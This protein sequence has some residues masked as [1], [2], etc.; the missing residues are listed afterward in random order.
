MKRCLFLIFLSVLGYAQ[1]NW[2]Y[3]QIDSVDIYQS[4]FGIINCLAIDTNGNP[5]VVYC[6]TGYRRGFYAYRLNDEW[7]KDRLVAG[8]VGHSLAY[9]FN[10]IAHLSFYIGDTTTTPITLLCYGTR[11]DSAN[12][13]ISVIDTIHY[14]FPGWNEMKTSLAFDTAG[15]PAIAYVSHDTIQPQ[16]IKYAHYNGYFWDTSVVEYE[17][18]NNRWT[19]PPSLKFD[20]HNKPHIVFTKTEGSGVVLRYYTYDSLNHW[21][22]RWSKPLYGGGTVALDLELDS[23]QYP[24]IA[25]GEGA[26]L[27]YSW[28]DGSSWQ[29]DYIT[30][31]GW[32]GVRIRLALDNYD[33]PHIIYLPDM[34][35][36]V[37]YCYK[38]STWHNVWLCPDTN[39]GTCTNQDIDIQF[40]KKFCIMHA[41]YPSQTMGIPFSFLSHAWGEVVTKINEGKR[42]E[43][44]EAS[45]GFNIYPNISSGLLNV[46]WIQG[47][48]GGIELTIYDVCGKRVKSI[49][50]R[51][52]PIGNCKKTLNISDLASGIYFI[53]LK[54]NDKQVSKKFAI[55]R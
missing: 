5:G 19:W 2:Q 6:S 31:I 1:V 20:K 37:W 28:W 55:I 22:L 10:N 16:Y 44:K 46:E 18:L 9:D 17:G 39:T 33:Q 54:Q 12:W 41:L 35:C 32:V 25:Y 47:F 3:E 29:T 38:D 50:E 40:D 7:H 52:C 23:D 11:I 36:R 13:Q 45:I 4:Y 27:A 34:M 48:Q 24:H 53:V 51:N 26:G 43:I 42:S 8:G 30:G 49:T 21:T 14:H 15:L